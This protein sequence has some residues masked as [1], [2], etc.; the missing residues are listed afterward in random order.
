MSLQVVLRYARKFLR[1]QEAVYLAT[2]VLGI[3]PE[4]TRER[5]VRALW[6][7]PEQRSAG[8]E[9]AAC[10]NHLER[11]ADALERKGKRRR[12]RALRKLIAEMVAARGNGAVIHGST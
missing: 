12:A 11:A 2:A 10:A 5:F 4:S 7:P 8:D 3:V 9:L 6:P 1:L